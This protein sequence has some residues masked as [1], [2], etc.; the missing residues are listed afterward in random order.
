MNSELEPESASV[1]LTERMKSPGLEFS[2]IEVVYLS[3]VKSGGLSF[4]SR[5]MIV[6]L[7]SLVSRVSIGPLSVAMTTN[8][9]SSP[10]SKSMGLP[11]TTSPVL[12]TM[13]NSP[14]SF[15]AVME[16]CTVLFSPKSGS[17]EFICSMKVLWGSFS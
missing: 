9:Y 2:G 4:L 17:V 8:L 14:S 3:S 11:T 12:A 15:P 5:M 10:T 13:S 6:T 1:A 7:V 16:Y